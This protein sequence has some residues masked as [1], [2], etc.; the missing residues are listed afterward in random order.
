MLSF[1]LFKSGNEGEKMFLALNEMKTA[2]LRY[3][4]IMGLL[5]LIAYLMYFLSGLAFGLIEENRSA[6]DNWKADTILLSKD[7]NASLNFS[8]L[9][10]KDKSE[11]KAKQV[12]E[13][14]EINTVVWNKKDPKESDKEK[15]AFFG[16]D[17]TSSLIPK[18][19]N[20]RELRNKEEILIDQSLAQ[21]TNF[22]VGDTLTEANSK[23]KFKIVGI[24]KK[25]TFNVAPVIHLSLD[26]FQKLNQIPSSKNN[27]K[28]NAYVVKGKI[29]SFNESKFQKMT[30][31][32]FIQKL[33]GYN[34]QVLTFGFMIGFLILIS[35]IIIG[36]FMYVLTIQ[37]APIF[38][39]MKA[40]GIANK[41][42]ANAVISQTIILSF[43]GSSLGLLGTWLSS[44]VL[45]QAVPFQGNWVL[46]AVIFALMMLFAILGSLFSVI[47][48]VRIDPLK[49]IG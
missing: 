13:L 45:P 48:I 21:K 41:T 40:Q 49:S 25:A 19:I 17:K 22:K 36:I 20:G 26:D 9:S 28:V 29:E 27:L 24:T 39:I 6:I 12:E 14:A 4:L 42:I 30:S 43:I 33:P 34:A 23:E 31:K 11:I 5:L 10:L 38:G 1:S 2:K 47:A 46:Y 35:A 37:K 3:S 16:L 44:I 18:V 8:K 15:V 32:K 7:A